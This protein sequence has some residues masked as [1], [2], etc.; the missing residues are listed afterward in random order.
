MVEDMT[1]FVQQIEEDIELIQRDWGHID[2][3]LDKKEYAFN[4][5]VLSRLFSI[6]DELIPELITEYSDKAIDRFAFYEDSKEIYIIQNKFY[7]LDDP[8]KRNH[9]TDFLKTP[10][11]VLKNGVY[12][13]SL[14]LQNAFNKAKEDPEYKVFFYFF[15]TSQKGNTDIQLLVSDFNNTDFELSCYVEAKFFGIADIYDLY[16][17]RNYKEDIKFK[18]MLGTL[19]RG[20]FASLREEY[21]MDQ[22]YEA[23]YI[24]TPISEL[25]K[26]LVCAE[27]KGY[28]IF[29]RNIREYLGT[30]P[31]NTGIVETLKSESERKNFM[32]YNNG[33]SIVCKKIE[34]DYIDSGSK[35][36]V[37]P[38]V[39]PQIVNGCQTV[40]SIKKVLENLSETEIKQGYKKVYVM[41]KALVIDDMDDEKNYSFYNN[42]VK[43][44]NKQNAISDKAFMSNMDVF[45]RL[46]E[47]F[48]KRG[49]LLLVKP[50]DKHK[51][52]EEL[53]K[54]DRVDFV[55][56]A[57]R[58]IDKLNLSI[59]DFTD[60]FIPLEKMLQV[61]LAFMKTGYYAFTKKIRY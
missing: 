54:A 50:S 56:R 37:L 4:Y 59:V 58:T 30:N 49:F 57:N 12:Q 5:W 35:L 28:N 7:A 19:N 20:T 17:G 43:Y 3:H 33:I 61:F 1:M 21:E 46:Q 14:V 8:V 6:D 44:T 16:Y 52:K 24:V 38:L 48:K 34:S 40:N 22:L 11:T 13:K 31:I 39:Q 36:R 60:V 53:S 26:M 47:E 9:I 25:Y 18:H 45:Y 32:Y 27:D 51:F 29:A 42:V 55:Q 41:V 10:M 15:A 23:Y 2:E